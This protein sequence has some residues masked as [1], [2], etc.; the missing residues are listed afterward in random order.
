MNRNITIHDLARIAG[1]SSSTISRS[2]SDNPVIPE[3]T[4][5]AVRRIAR[6]HGYRPNTLATSLR[7]GKSMI[8]GVVVPRINRH[9]FSNVIG[10]ME[11][12]LNEAG[13]TLMICQSGEKKENE[14]SGIRSLINMRVDAV[15]LSLATGNNDPSYLL[16]L[17]ERKI[18]V[19]MF[20]RV[21]HKLPFCSVSLDDFEASFKATKHLLDQ[22]Y[23]KLVH[24]SGPT[25]ISV[26]RERKRGY[27]EALESS[28]PGNH[29]VIIHDVLTRETGAACMKELL[30]EGM[31]PDAVFAASDFSALGALMAAREA[32]LNIPG[33]I[34]IAGFA[35]EPFT[36][37]MQPGITTTDQNP[38]EMGR[39]V[40]RMFLETK[41]SEVPAHLRINSELIIRESTQ[42][43]KYQA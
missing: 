14:I 5:A 1:L 23:K 21:D 26:Y 41:P 10:G 35:N 24:F 13:Y 11:E 37:L 38:D 40:A 30:S 12:V 20:D 27:I 7:K 2:L 8:A 22:G 32:G 43:N 4:R 3:T 28:G 9:F 29:P 19:Y 34:G 36:G 42:K 18:P 16:E 33:D 15:F 39:A 25:H 17:A 6:E 31:Y